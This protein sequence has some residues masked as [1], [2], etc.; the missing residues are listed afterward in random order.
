M[1]HATPNAPL[2]KFRGT[3]G[4]PPKEAP[5]G[6]DTG[7]PELVMKRARG[8]T[9]EPIDQCLERQLITPDQHRAAMHLRWLHTVRYGAPGVTALDLTRGRGMELFEEDDPRW[10]AHREQEYREALALIR[11]RG[12]DAELLPCIIYG[13]P[14]RFLQ[15]QSFE[16]AFT[17]HTHAD[18]LLRSAARFAEGLELLVKHWK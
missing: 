9:A 16:R 8:E 13:E 2:R 5:S 12:Y 4:R 18:T 10:R 3:R 14:P 11:A 17:Q 1:T 7:T 6:D 15:R